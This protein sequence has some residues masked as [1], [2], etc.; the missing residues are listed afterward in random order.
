MK[1]LVSSVF[2]VAA[3]LL[4]SLVAR[5]QDEARMDSIVQ[6]LV[7]SKQFMGTVLVA[8]GDQVLFDKAYGQANAEWAVAN[9]TNTKFRI[10]S[11]TKQFTAASILLLEERGKLKVDD[12]IRKHYA[13]APAAWDGITLKHLLTHSSGI[14]NLTDGPEFE[15]RKQLVT[16]LDET[17]AWFRD[18][19][20]D[21]A[22]GERMKYSNSGYIMLGYVI[23]KVSGGSYA[24]FVQQNILTPVGMKD[25]GYD[26]NADIIERRASGYV[27]AGG[28]LRNADYVQMSIPHAAGG[29]YSTTGDLLRWNRALYGGKVLKPE[30]L[31]KMTTPFKDRYAFG[32]SSG[33]SSGRKFFEHGGGIEG[34]NT[35]LIYYPASQ[36][37]IV[38]LSNVN[39]AAPGQI[40][41]KLGPLA[42]GETVKL[43]S[44]RTEIKLPRDRLER[45]VGTYALSPQINVM[46][47]LDGDHLSTQLS[48]QPRVPTFAESETKFFVRL[49]DAQWEFFA[50]PS[51]TVT[52]VVLYQNGRETKAPRTSD[53]VTERREISLPVAALQDYVGTFALRPGLDLVF[54]IEDDTLVLR[55][56]N[57]GRDVMF[58]EA[59]DKFFS[60]YIDASIEFARDA[61]GKVSQL[62][63]KQGAFTGVAKRK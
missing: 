61:T 59:K 48:G 63:L 12:P 38:A 36:I 22:P 9:T 25:S 23:E 32:I 17:I 47:R 52:H 8:R 60:K 10:G 5:A 20:L 7:E 26:S 33:E 27:N 14:P 19:P 13:N 58:A 41:A 50:D 54:S 4:A 62:T 1:A 34:F 43:T 37:T 30:S 44:E 18:K 16:S 53:T 46:V 29:L 21:F 39:G 40:L 28:K 42:H 57:Q 56:T 3:L 11:I 45:Y 31:A 24:D 6:P 49:V 35:Q 51:G 55:P 2:A 15:R